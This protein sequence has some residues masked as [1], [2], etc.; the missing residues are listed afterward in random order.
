MYKIRRSSASIRVPTQFSVF[1][2]PMERLAPEI[3]ILILR[4]VDKDA[5]TLISCAGVNHAWRPL[6]QMVLFEKH[7]MYTDRTKSADLLE[8]WQAKDGAIPFVRILVFNML[9]LMAGAPRVADIHN[10]WADGHFA[11]LSNLDQ[12]FLGP[13]LLALSE[14]GVTNEFVLNLL[15][16]H[17]V[18]FAPLPVLSRLSRLTLTGMRFDTVQT[19]QVLL[20]SLP[21]LTSLRLMSVGWLSHAHQYYDTLGAQMPLRGLYITVDEHHPNYAAFHVLYTWILWLPAARTLE[22]VTYEKPDVL[23]EDPFVQFI[24]SLSHIPGPALSVP[25]PHIILRTCPSLPL[26]SGSHRSSARD[27]PAGHRPRLG[28]PGHINDDRASRGRRGRS[29]T[30]MRLRP[31]PTVLHQRPGRPHADAPAGQRPRGRHLRE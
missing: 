24:A 13:R 9:P 31:P 17:R 18:A 8:C 16:P 27:R 29:H 4:N 11:R 25:F 21:A 6:A 19:L 20:R 23:T 28:P 5:K 30:G 26:G 3:K 12:L 15:P 22:D 10:I 14:L 7:P 2:F 1:I